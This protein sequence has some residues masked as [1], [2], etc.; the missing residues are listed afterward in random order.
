MSESVSCSLIQDTFPP[1]TLHLAAALAV[2][3][4]LSQFVVKLIA[5]HFNDIKYYKKFNLGRRL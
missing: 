5:F 3:V 1:Q 2:L 4:H